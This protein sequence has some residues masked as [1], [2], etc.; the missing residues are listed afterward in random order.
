MLDVMSRPFLPALDRDGRRKSDLRLSF[1]ENLHGYVIVR[2]ELNAEK[3]LPAPAGPGH[4][5]V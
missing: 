4:V 2:A 1:D 3:L 5:A